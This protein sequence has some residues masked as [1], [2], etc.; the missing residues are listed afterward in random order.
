V[1]SIRQAYLANCLLQNGTGAGKKRLA[2]R[3]EKPVENKDLWLQLLGLKDRFSR[4]TF[5]K[6]A[7]TA[8]S[9]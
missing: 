9:S 6:V 4:I 8:T 2:D 1:R 5:H 3:G 7:A